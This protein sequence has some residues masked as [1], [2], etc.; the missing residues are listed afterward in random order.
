MKKDKYTF[1]SKNIGLFGLGNILPKLLSFIIIPLYTRKISV[2]EYGVIELINTTIQLLLPVF[3]L[4]IQ[5]AILRF[6]FDAKWQRKHIFSTGIWIAFAGMFII[7]LGMYLLSFSGVFHFDKIYLLYIA[8]LFFV[9]AISQSVTRFCRG[10]D[11]VTTV[12]VG[13]IINSVIASTGKIILLFLFDFGIHGYIL[14]DIVGILAGILY[15][16]FRARLYRYITIKIPKELVRAMIGFSFPLVFSAMAWWI[17]NASDRYILSWMQ[18]VSD[19]GIYAM[20]NK[21]PNIVVSIQVI[22]QQAWSLSV[23]KDFSK[24]DEDGFIGKT[25]AIINFIT[26]ICCSMIM[27]FNIPIAHLLYSGE[28]FNAWKYVPILSVAIMLNGVSMFLDSVFLATKTTKLISTSTII[29]AVVN[30]IFN[31]ILIYFYGVYGAAVATVLGYAVG[32]LYRMLHLHQYIQMRMEWNKQLLSFLLIAIQALL[33]MSGMRWIL[34]QC[35]ILLILFL[36]HKKYVKD[37]LTILKA[38]LFI[39]TE[40]S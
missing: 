24:N 27:I 39:T 33:A 10:V 22:I 8:I 18:S 14:S 31:I 35:V 30:T 16:F 12:V 2:Y 25:F 5:E 36:L 7:I 6:V 4:S 40:D 23:I 17:N 1:L 21:I 32:L 37:I 3:T 26:F 29:G 15:A 13:S 28:Y 38:K 11:H 19:S 20:S 34:V 9:D